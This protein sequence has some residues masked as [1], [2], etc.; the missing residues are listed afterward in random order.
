MRLA[1]SSSPLPLVITDAHCFGSSTA[2]IYYAKDSW[3][4]RLCVRGREQL[5]A[6][7]DAFGVP[8][9]KCGKLIV[10]QAHQ[11]PPLLDCMAGGIRATLN[12]FDAVRVML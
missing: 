6:F 3:K 2:G 4:A 7:C 9:R 5:Y 12:A 1:F 10:A 8:Y 11:V